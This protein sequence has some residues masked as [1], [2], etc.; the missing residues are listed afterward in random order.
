MGGRDLDSSDDEDD[1]GGQAAPA[2]PAEDTMGT[3]ADE[4]PPP[5]TRFYKN[6]LMQSEWMKALP[7]DLA[8]S[9]LFTICPAGKR[10]LVISRKGQTVAYARNGKCIKRFPSSL[11]GGARWQQPSAKEYCILDCVLDFK[12]STF[13]VLDLMCWRGHEVFDSDTEFRAYWLASKFEEEPAP[14]HRAHGNPCVFLPM[15]LVPCT[16]EG[17]IAAVTKPYHTAI[18]GV[19]FYHKQTH[20]TPGPTPL[21]LW[22][23]PEMLQDSLGIPIPPIPPPIKPIE[24]F[25]TAMDAG[26]GAGSAPVVFQPAAGVFAQ[27]SAAPRGSDMS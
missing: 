14:M 8:E 10:C 2:A 27:A 3:A 7:A 18:D 5:V 13:Y 23:K 19:L 9:W 16:P 21:V 4:K 12:T 25:D 26:A 20:Y 11:P 15:P 17:I 1:E 22:L 6:Q 24:E